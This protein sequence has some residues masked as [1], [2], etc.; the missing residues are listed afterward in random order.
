M[1][2]ASTEEALNPELTALFWSL[3]GAVAYSLMTQ[4]WIDGYVIA[5]QRVTHK[6]FMNHVRCLNALEKVMQK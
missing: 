3:L 4:Q 6:P 2:G 1:T 5:L